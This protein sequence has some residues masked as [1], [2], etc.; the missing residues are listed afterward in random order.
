MMNFKVSQ[1]SE[2]KDPE[3]AAL[4][5]VAYV[6]QAHWR[7][8]KKPPQGWSDL[9]DQVSR[10]RS[11]SRTKAI[12]AINKIRSLNYQMKWGVEVY[13]LF[14]EDKHPDSYVIGESPDGRLKVTSSGTIIK[15]EAEK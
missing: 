7:S 14:G 1:S 6:Y 11:E 3:E 13:K 8:K 15:S 12:D 9:E 10:A 5:T 4:V 2:P